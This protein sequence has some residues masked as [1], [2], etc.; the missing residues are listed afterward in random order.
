MLSQD[1]EVEASPVESRQ[2]LY[3]QIFE[4][5]ICAFWGKFLRAI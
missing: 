2:V 5:G 4:F 3:E 1:L